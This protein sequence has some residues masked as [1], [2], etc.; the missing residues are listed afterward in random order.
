MSADMDFKY[1]RPKLTKAEIPA[2]EGRSWY[3]AETV[4]A[5]QC[6][7]L[8]TLPVE[9]FQTRQIFADTTNFKKYGFKR[10]IGSDYIK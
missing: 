9:D 7:L 6:F 3:E 5:Y 1:A 8:S 2:C 4:A 10:T